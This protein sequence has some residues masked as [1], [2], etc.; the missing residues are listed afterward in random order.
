MSNFLP[1]KS[2]GLSIYFWMTKEDDWMMK[3]FQL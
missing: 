2:K 1:L 3:V